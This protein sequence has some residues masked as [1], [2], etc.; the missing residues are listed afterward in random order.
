MKKVVHTRY[1]SPEVL[2]FKEVE[3]PGIGDGDVL[4]KVRATA[5]NAYDWHILRADPFL[6][7][8][9][10]G[11]FKPKKTM[12]GVDIAGEVEAVGKNVQQFRPGDEVFADLSACGGGGFAEYVSVP[13]TELALK[14]TNLS[15]VE[16]AAVPMAAVTALQGL[17]DLGKVQPGKK[18]LINGASGGVG[19]FAVQL[20]RVLGA[21]I[22]AVCSSSKMEMV[23]SL[24]AD[25]VIDYG[26]EDF[27]QHRQRYDMILAVNG[28]LPIAL[29]KQLL[30]P[31]GIY[32][33]AG[34]SNTQIFQAMLFGP[35]LSLTGG[36]KLTILSARPKQT[37]LVFVKTLLENGK[38]YPVMDR[39]YPFNEVQ[40]AIRYLEK[41]HA[42]GK[43]VVTM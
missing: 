17:R 24:G 9:S 28:Y 40:E 5:V 34:G 2:E 7:R 6:A 19:T 31:Q 3:M 33:M 14:P 37:D 1:G 25:H 16:A 8:L 36:K 12:L 23:R 30:A 26:R 41:G 22:T 32:I 29:Y 39:C 43:V 42:K 10:V 18:V 15:F 13:E 38:I 4:V 35:W 21:E 20:A 11:L 27:T